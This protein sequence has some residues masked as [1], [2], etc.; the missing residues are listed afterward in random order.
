MSQQIHDAVLFAFF[1]FQKEIADS[2]ALNAKIIKKQL[3]RKGMA[4]K[5]VDSDPAAAA[6]SNLEE[7]SRRDKPRG[8]LMSEK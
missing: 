1:F 7:S 8:T 4:T 5:K 3:D 2:Y 6:G